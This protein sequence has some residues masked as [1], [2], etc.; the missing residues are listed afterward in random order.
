MGKNY[1]AQV[2][3][4]I[5]LNED[6]YLEKSSAAYKK[7]KNILLKWMERESNSRKHRASTYRSTN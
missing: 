2:V 7:D 4:N 3:I 6:G 1:N 5:A